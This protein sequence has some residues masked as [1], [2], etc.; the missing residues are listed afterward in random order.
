MVY[1]VYKSK[2]AENCTFRELFSSAGNNIKAEKVLSSQRSEEIQS[3]CSAER[4]GAAE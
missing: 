3:R 2:I 4:A 1:K